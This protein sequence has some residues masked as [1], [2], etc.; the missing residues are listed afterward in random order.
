MHLCICSTAIRSI[1]LLSCYGFKFYHET[2][3]GDV[4]E[5][6][7]LAGN[8]PRAP[9]EFVVG[10]VRIE[11]KYKLIYRLIGIYCRADALAYLRFIF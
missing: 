1:I 11:I 6:A 5:L 2:M 3:L 10:H 8:R 4:E 9:S 7:Y